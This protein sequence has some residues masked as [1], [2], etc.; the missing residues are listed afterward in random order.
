M[1]FVISGYLITSLIGREL[2]A[3]KFT[4]ASFYERRIRRIF[5]AL[6]VVMGCTVGAGAI[7][8]LPSDFKELAETVTASA[9][10]SSNFLFWMRTGYFDAA[11]KPLLHTWSLAVEEQYYIVVPV[12]MLLIYRFTPKYVRSIFLGAMLFSLGVSCWGVAYHPSAAFYLAPSRAWELLL[13]ALLALTGSALN[14]SPRMRAAVAAIGLGMIFFAVLRFT[15]RTPFPGAYALVP[16][17]GTGLF[18]LAGEDPGSYVNRL[19]AS[20]PLVLI[21]LISYSLYLW[22]WPLLVL[23]PYVLLRSLSTVDVFVLVIA[24]VVIAF[25]SWR[26]IE[27][28]FRRRRAALSRNGIYVTAT[29]VTVALAGT[30][31]TVQMFDGIPARFSDHVIQMTAGNRDFD[32]ALAECTSIA[33]DASSKTDL[34]LIGGSTAPSFLVWGDSHAVALMPALRHLARA[35]GVTGWFANYPGCPP[36]LG[37]HVID[38]PRTDRCRQFNDAVANFIRDRHIKHV[39]LVS[40]W[41]AY[42][43]G[44]PAGSIDTAPDPFLA[45]AWSTEYTQ[46]ASRQVFRRA[47]EKTLLR[48]GVDGA[49]VWLV[50]QP[51]EFLFDPPYLVARSSIRKGEPASVSIARTEYEQRQAFVSKT[52]DEIS[53]HVKFERVSPDRMLCDA[54]KCRALDQGRSLYRDNDHLSVAGALYVAPL[55]EPMF[56]AIGNKQ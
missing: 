7:L 34:C 5:P 17:I 27:L 26:F 6:V 52:L 8:Y 44:Y 51:P 40:R 28:P 20:P 53:A 37:V 55:L 54:T 2:A 33:L 41:N 4:V 22:H 36:L 11:P 13:G 23:A 56:R 9:V 49:K 30:G 21:G 39:M 1:F 50:E 18:I 38:A 19:V 10:F 12:V 29:S 45:D 3:G 15:P 32:V 35:F 24:S 42:A 31:I 16:V 48:L 14:V 43:S 25:L 46:R 47:L